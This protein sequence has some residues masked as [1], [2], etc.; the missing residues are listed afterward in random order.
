VRR[1]PWRRQATHTVECVP[2]LP[3][4]QIPDGLYH[5]GVRGV[6]KT[7]LF[8]DDPDRHEILGRLAEVVARY[9]W[10]CL[11]Y[12]LMTN[13]VH[14]VV[15]T[16][17]PTISRGMQWLNSRYCEY[18]NGRYGI[19]GHAIERRFWSKVI[20]REEQLLTTIAYDVLNPVRA[21]I[22]AHPGDWPWSSYLATAGRAPAPSW[23]AVDQVQRMF[24]SDAVIGAAL[25][26]E[27]VDA[28]SV[29]DMS[30]V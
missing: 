25:F 29:R 24:A 14:L 13:H 5:V 3:R 2:R 26:V 18:F 22:C 10:E 21:G 16:I 19:E 20:T 12:C 7:P 30:G 4:P 23:L 17:E 15:K 28:M 11:A 27:F 8:H 6:R 1:R 9:C